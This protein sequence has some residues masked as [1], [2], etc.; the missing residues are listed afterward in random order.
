MAVALP[1]QA[2]NQSG[3]LFKPEVS[4]TRYYSFRSRI[5][6]ADSSRKKDGEGLR[7]VL[8]SNPDAVALLN[9]YQA[10]LKSP[11]WPAYIGTVGIATLIAGSLAA[12]HLGAT[13]VR[14]NNI[15]WA[16][17][18]AGSSVILGSYFYS[19]RRMK[20]NEKTLDRAVDTYNNT[21]PPEDRIRVGF[22]P[23]EVGAGAQIKT[24]VKF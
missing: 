9:D 3:D 8:K 4:C 5:Y 24:E 15:R 1:C 10:T 16:F 13:K 19:Y 11:P 2:S 17:I 22:E 12:E 7:Q 14:R 20:N 21:A 18:G 6:P 23:S